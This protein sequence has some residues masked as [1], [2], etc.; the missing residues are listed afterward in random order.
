MLHVDYTHF[1]VMSS[2]ELSLGLSNIIYIVQN[3]LILIL[4]KFFS[5]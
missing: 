4:F 3:N 2:S 5:S 1:F